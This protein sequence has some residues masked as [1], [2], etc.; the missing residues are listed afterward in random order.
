MRYIRK[1][2]NAGSVLLHDHL[3]FPFTGIE[4]YAQFFQSFRFDTIYYDLCSEL[5][6]SA[7]ADM[8]FHQI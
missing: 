3:L 4:R 8:R 6:G 1:H 5:S 2:K 7:F